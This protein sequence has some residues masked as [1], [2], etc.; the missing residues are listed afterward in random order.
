MHV[1]LFVILYFLLPLSLSLSA[2]MGFAACLSHL[3]LKTC[4]P[5]A[6]INAKPG[7]TVGLDVT[8]KVAIISRKEQEKR[9]ELIHVL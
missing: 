3:H 7:D 2:L 8:V 9:L 1:W 5:P 4:A 6:T